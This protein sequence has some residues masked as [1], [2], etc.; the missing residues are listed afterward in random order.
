MTR[1]ARCE[2]LGAGDNGQGGAF[3]LAGHVER[4]HRRPNLRQFRCNLVVAQFQF[5]RARE[6]RFQNRPRRP[7]SNKVQLV[8]ELSQ[9]PREL[10]AGTFR[11]S[12][13]GHSKHQ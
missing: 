11:S 8:T 3:Y 9:P 10:R 2:G 13:K 5:A 6:E 1:I 4:L 12:W 7:V